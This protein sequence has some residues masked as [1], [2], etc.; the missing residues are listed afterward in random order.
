MTTT[1]VTL[2]G[3]A[4]GTGCAIWLE[5]AEP[6]R[7]GVLVPPIRSEDR[8]VSREFSL[9]VVNGQAVATSS[10]VVTTGGASFQWNELEVRSVHALKL[11]KS[12][13]S[14][15][16]VRQVPQVNEMADGELQS[17]LVQ[18]PSASGCAIVLATLDLSSLGLLR[19]DA[20]VRGTLTLTMSDT[21]P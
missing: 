9:R 21:A 20:I 19:A 15:L 17:I 2:Q 10:C 7:F 6:I 5:P 1:D 14:G 3:D 18:S 11:S 4:N 12:P 8:L 13:T 16:S